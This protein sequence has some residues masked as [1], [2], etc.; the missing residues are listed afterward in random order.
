MCVCM[1]SKFT[2]I[3]SIFYMCYTI[4]IMQKVLNIDIHSRIYILHMYIIYV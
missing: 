1:Y 4:Y 2:C 3:Y